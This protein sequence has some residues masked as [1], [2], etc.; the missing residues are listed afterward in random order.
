MQ[1]PLRLPNDLKIL[2]KDLDFEYPILIIYYHF[3]LMLS[4]YYQN[5]ILIL[6]LP[7]CVQLIS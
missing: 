4:I 1:L 2:L 3:L 6:I 7:I 5:S